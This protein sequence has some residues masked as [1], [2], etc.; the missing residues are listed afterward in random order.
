[1]TLEQL[2]KQVRE[3]IRK[4]ETNKAFEVLAQNLDQ[5]RPVFNEL[6]QI[7]ARWSDT[8]KREM[9]GTLERDQVC[10]EYSRV[11]TRLLNLLK[12]LIDDDLGAG[13]S[14]EDPF[15]AFVRE[16]I[17]KGPL[18]HPIYIVN[19][20][21]KQPIQYFWKRFDHYNEARS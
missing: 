8:F 9:G 1:M 18:T 19:C 13:G 10:Q 16:L 6:V 5:E 11:E 4:G 3:L 17:L 2:R 14:L 15:D 21:R 12:E 20:D 7:N